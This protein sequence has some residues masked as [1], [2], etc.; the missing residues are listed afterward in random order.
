[1]AIH[2]TAPTQSHFWKS[3]SIKNIFYPL[4]KCFL[5]KPVSMTIKK[6]QD[7]FMVERANQLI[8]NMLVTKENNNKVFDYIDPWI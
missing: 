4:L 6:P 2:I 3:I 8:Y 7:K 1:M 5:I